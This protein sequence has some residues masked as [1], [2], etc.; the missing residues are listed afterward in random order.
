MRTWNG[1]GS[2]AWCDYQIAM[3]WNSRLS[4]SNLIEILMRCQ[5]KSDTL[6]L[7]APARSPFLLNCSARQTCS[8]CTCFAIWMSIPPL[9]WGSPAVRLLT[10]GASVRG[11]AGRQVSFFLSLPLLFTLLIKIT[12]LPHQSRWLHGNVKA[13]GMASEQSPWTDGWTTLEPR[14]FIHGTVAS[15]CVSTDNTRGLIHVVVQYA[16]R[17]GLWGC[18]FVRKSG[19]QMLATSSPSWASTCP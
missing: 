16:E 1:R 5:M 12:S 17:G 18:E 19:L 10:L 4:I 13:A 9:W 2:R 14:L 7:S 15:I 11:Q 6:V 3:P 8:A